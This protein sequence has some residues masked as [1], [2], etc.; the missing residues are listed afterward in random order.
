ME[1]GDVIVR[2]EAAIKTPIPIS[3][4]IFIVLLNFLEGSY[5][6]GKVFS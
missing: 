4:S 3:D 2:N 1:G 6:D 5:C